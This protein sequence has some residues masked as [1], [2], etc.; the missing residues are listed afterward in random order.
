[1]RVALVGPVER[2]GTER[3]VPEDAAPVGVP[4][5][6]D[7]GHGLA[8]G[9]PER[10]NV[11]VPQLAPVARDDGLRVARDDRSRPGEE[12]AVRR[13]PRLCVVTD[14]V[15]RVAKE[16]KPRGSLK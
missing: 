16:R 10:V 1:M 2:G 8:D 9:Q 3:P 6:F 14:A 11:R 4:V 7:V 5:E 12:H 13:V 15:S